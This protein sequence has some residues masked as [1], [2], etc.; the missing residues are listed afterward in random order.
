M[1]IKRPGEEVQHRGLWDSSLPINKAAACASL[2]P[3]S[4]ENPVR[5]GRKV[6]IQIWL[7]FVN[8]LLSFKISE[9]IVAGPP[10]P[11]MNP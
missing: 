6:S 3:S 10:H 9:R 1:W 11:L 2:K 5:I 8:G 7:I 4:W